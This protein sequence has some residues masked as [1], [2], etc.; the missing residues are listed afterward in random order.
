MLPHIGAVEL[1]TQQLRAQCSGGLEE[2]K[3][4]SRTHSRS[5]VQ[6]W[7]NLWSALYSFWKS[8]AVDTDSGFTPPCYPTIHILHLRPGSPLTGR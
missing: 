8:K 4:R 3:G 1:V 6:P 7:R 5:G 2:M